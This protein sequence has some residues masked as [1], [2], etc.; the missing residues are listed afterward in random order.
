MLRALSML[1]AD[2]SWEQLHHT[3]FIKKCKYQRHWKLVSFVVV[4]WAL[5][6]PWTLN[7][8]QADP[9]LVLICCGPRR[10]GH[11][12]HDFMAMEQLLLSASPNWWVGLPA[13]IDQI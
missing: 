7:P 9:V 2:C 10:Q 5:L 12:R 8:G 11:G 4:A 13:V 3:F 6:L 1:L